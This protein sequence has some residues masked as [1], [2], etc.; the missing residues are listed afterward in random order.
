LSRS[1]VTHLMSKSTRPHVLS[2][3]PFAFA[4]PKN[5]NIDIPIVTS[6]TTRYLWGEKRR[7]YRTTLS[8]RTGINLHDCTSAK[9][10]RDDE[11]VESQSG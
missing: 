6:D 8:R 3:P 1:K 2:D 10:K 5:I 4:G 9:A 7:R 11:E